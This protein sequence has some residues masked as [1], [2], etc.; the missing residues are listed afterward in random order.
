MI[1]LAYALCTPAWVYTHTFFSEPLV[2]L[3]L[4]TAVFSMIRFAQSD[5]SRWLALA[6]GALGVALLTRVDAVAAIPAF[7]LYLGLVWW[8]RR[9]YLAAASGQSLAAAAPFAAGLGLALGYNY[10][11]FGSIL[12]FGYST[13]NWQSDFL[14]GL[15]GLT[16]SPGK[17]LVWYAPPIVLGL[18]SMPA[19]ARRFPREAL[20][21]LAL[22]AGIL[23]VHAPYTY[24]EGGWC[25]GPRLILPA[26]P[27]LLIPAAPLLAR[28]GQGGLR[29]L[30]IAVLLALGLVVQLPA[31]FC[32]PAHSL[33]AAYAAFPEEF[34]DRVLY[35]PAD[36]PIVRQWHS[37]AQV[38]ANLRYP[39]ARSRIEALLAATRPSQATLLLADSMAEAARLERHTL[40]AYN[41]PDLWL[42]TAPWL[43]EAEAP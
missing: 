29:S 22:A 13:S 10:H 3:C 31:L 12:E 36:A 6:G 42:V 15:I 26:L 19:F 18:I 21:C 30:G 39:A 38:T 11:R 40:L 5:Q 43:R 8:Q 1:A 35:R 24:W 27:F 14:T 37:L 25:W 32:E 9:P 23:A 7:A 20:L 41:L 16:L 17:G 28:P 33:Q 4:V 34:Q 2:T